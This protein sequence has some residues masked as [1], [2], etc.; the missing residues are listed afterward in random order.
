MRG[1]WNARRAA[2]FLVAGV[3]AFQCVV[4]LVGIVTC[5]YYSDLI[6]QQKVECRARDQLIELMVQALAA[7]LAFAGGMHSDD[8][9]K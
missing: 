6:I 1:G 2:F 7:A 8:K 3:I 5:V 4:V 9:D